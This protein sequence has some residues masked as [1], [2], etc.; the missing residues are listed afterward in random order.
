MYTSA[1]ALT[2]ST[3]PATSFCKRLADFGQVDKHHI[4]QRILRVVGDADDS[5]VAVNLQ[6]FVVFGVL[7]HEGAPCVGG[8]SFNWDLTN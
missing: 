7:D 4:A 2:D 8:L 1:A 3:T 6:P 5:G